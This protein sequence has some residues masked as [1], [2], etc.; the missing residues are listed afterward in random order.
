M[1]ETERERRKNKQT[2]KQTMITEAKRER[3]EISVPEFKERENIRKKEA[4][5]VSHAAEKLKNIMPESCPLVLQT[6]WPLVTLQLQDWWTGGGM[7][8]PN[9]VHSGGHGNQ[10]RVEKLDVC[11][12]TSLGRKRTRSAHSEGKVCKISY[13][14]AVCELG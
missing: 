6:D 2:N 13:N 5:G 4:I 10:G 12:A 7:G 14:R 9:F 1:R 3:A 11:S 8:R